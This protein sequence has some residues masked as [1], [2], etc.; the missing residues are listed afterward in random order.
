M[1]A[2]ALGRL[3]AAAV[4]GSGGLRRCVALLG[5]PDTDTLV[6]SL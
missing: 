2:A 1:T 3:G 6:G 5:M 4:T